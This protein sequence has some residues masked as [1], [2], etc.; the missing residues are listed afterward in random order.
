MLQCNKMCNKIHTSGVNPNNLKEIKMFDFEKQ[1]KDALE[2]FETLTS[3]TKASYEFWYNCVMDTW[4]DL[5][6]K[7]K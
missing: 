1:Y 5:Y 4:K 6:S 3:Q 2:K 7:K